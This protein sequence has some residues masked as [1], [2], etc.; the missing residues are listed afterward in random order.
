ML[1]V[2]RRE[3]FRGPWGPREDETGPRVKGDQSFTSSPTEGGCVL[4]RVWNVSC[5][6]RWEGPVD[7][8]PSETQSGRPSPDGEWS[9]HWSLFN[10][11]ERHVK[12]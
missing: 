4:P 3:T 12:E 11:D 5:D 1:S 7:I 10:E 6:G 2:L 8:V 9:T